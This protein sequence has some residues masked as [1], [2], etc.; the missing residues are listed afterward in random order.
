MP[1]AGASDRHPARLP[2]GARRR[3]F[4]YVRKGDEAR[5]VI[6]G[7]V[8]GHVKTFSTTGNAESEFKI[9]QKRLRRHVGDHV[10]PDAWLF[11]GSLQLTRAQGRDAVLAKLMPS[12]AVTGSRAARPG[13][14]SIPHQTSPAGPAMRLPLPVPA[15]TR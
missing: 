14:G 2:S 1:S 3:P 7:A 13:F 6:S 5:P 15:M 9:G 12:E 11:T 4:E 10:E 8:C